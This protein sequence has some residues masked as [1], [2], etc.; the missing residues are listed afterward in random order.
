MAKLKK[1]VYLGT[2]ESVQTLKITKSNFE[3]VW[4]LVKDDV[5]VT[6]ND[7]G[8]L[9]KKLIGSYVVKTKDRQFIMGSKSFENT[10]GKESL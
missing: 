8:Y 10:F 5:K 9:H 2:G 6:K 3:D 4:E 1:A 7:F